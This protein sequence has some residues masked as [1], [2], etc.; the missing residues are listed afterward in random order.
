MMIP[1]HSVLPE[2]AQREVRCIHLGA[3]PDSDF[4]ADE[5]AYVEYYCNDLACDC[6]RVFLKVISKGQPGKV[7]AGISYGYEEAVLQEANAVEPGRG[8]GNGSR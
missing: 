7:F 2:L 5:Y 1:F 6:R 3:A 4:P 8:Q